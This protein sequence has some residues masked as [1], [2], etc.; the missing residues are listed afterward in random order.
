MNRYE[1]FWRLM[2]DDHL[3]QD[4]IVAE[5]PQ[6]EKYN[7]LVEK[8]IT[9]YSQLFD[10]IRNER[11]DHKLRWEAC[12]AV[13]RLWNTIDRRRAV[14]CLLT[15]LNTKDE[16]VRCAAA[17]TL[18]MLKSKRA[19]VPLMTILNDKSES[20]TVRHWVIDGLSLIGDNRALPL[21]W[22][23]IDDPTEHPEI[24]SRAIEMM[25]ESP[26]PIE[27]L[28]A[29]FADPLPDIRF[30][31]A[32]ALSFSPPPEA[33]AELDRIVAYDHT[34]PICWGWHVDREAMLPL[35]TIFYRKLLGYYENNE[36]EEYPWYGSGNFY[37]I[38]PAPE[39]W[40]LSQRYR[41]SKDDWT[42]TTDALPEIKLR[43]EP[44]WLAE[45]LQKKW[46]RIRL[47]VREPRP[48]AYLLDW[49]LQSGEQ[50]L[51][52]A[53]HRDQYGVV[54]TGD[55]LVYTF[56]EWYRGLFPDTQRLYL[57]QWADPHTELRPGM[58]AEAIEEANNRTATSAVELQAEDLT[59]G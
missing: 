28:I 23:I 5:K 56:A 30:W 14:P 52:G 21:F 26:E 36:A 17:N 49:H 13:H 47:N 58:T 16:Q 53:L 33:L 11:N 44:D 9:T 29:L 38:S 3:L 15:A 18:G 45:K 57:Y 41:K 8:K 2:D 50:H 7:W 46:P 12:Y 24:R 32:Y 51:I 20:V 19:V 22:Q 42:Y 10:F 4:L 59:F 27:R 25:F 31:A 6:G 55:D 34:L 54:L 35:E 48:Q 40:T 1:P 43:I 37:L 39:Y